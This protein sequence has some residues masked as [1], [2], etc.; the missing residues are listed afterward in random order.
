[1]D[2]AMEIQ[3]CSNF[4]EYI[5]NE[6]AREFCDFWSLVLFL[7]FSNCTSC[8]RTF[9]TSPVLINHKMHLH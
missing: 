8:M 2:I 4:V 6:L 1:M 9:K 5:M 3:S 7:K